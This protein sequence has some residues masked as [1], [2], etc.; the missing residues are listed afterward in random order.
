MCTGMRRFILV[1]LQQLGKMFLSELQALSNF[2]SAA[3]RVEPF[4][5]R[6]KTNIYH[7]FSLVLNINT[8]SSRAGC[9]LIQKRELAPAE[10]LH[11]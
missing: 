5:L 7:A 11:F 10:Q 2:V 8:S 6:R 4:L 1:L 9:I 3:S